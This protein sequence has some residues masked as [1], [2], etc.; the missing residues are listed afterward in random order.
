MNKIFLPN[1][2]EAVEAEYE[3][4]PI[5]EYSNNPYI[6]AL[7]TI[8]D[9][10]GIIKGLVLN[11]PFDINERNF[12]SPIRIHILQR[13]YK[14]FQPLPIHLEVWRTIDTLIRQ[15]Y[16]A[17][18]P[19]D[20]EYRQY[21]NSIGSNVSKRVYEINAR[22][23][24]TT[25]SSCGLIV[26]FSGM[27]KTTCVNR[28]LSNF[29]Q[30]ICHNYYNDNHFNQL[31]LT[32]LRLEAP[33]SLKSL[34]IQFF[35]KTD[36]L[37]GT[38]NLK[39]YMTKNLS[40]DAL[41]S[42]MGVVCNNI[43]LGLLIID[44]IQNLNRN[45]V[46]QIMNF[47]TSLINTCGVPVLFIGTP[48]SY[49]I[50]SNELRIARRVTGNSELIWNNMNNDRQFRVLL[51]GIW[52]YQ[53]TRKPIELTENMANLFYN[54]TQG[55]SDLVVKL[56]VNTQ[57]LAIEVGTEEISEALVNKVA[58]EQ[59]KFIK[60]MIEAIRSGN[61]YKINEYEDIRR[62]DNDST[63]GNKEKEEKE[64]SKGRGPTLTVKSIHKR[65]SIK[66]ELEENDFRSIIKKGHENKKSEYEALKE[67]GVIDD[68]VWAE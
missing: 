43:G 40:T 3:L 60:P 37:L 24:F 58:E 21:L 6:Q 56:F 18:N 49:D 19:F 7:P 68:M 52:R 53:W 41:L 33:T 9:K 59:F 15:G 10:K 67:E 29:P 57:R 44:E 22:T 66:L 51:R 14:V 8:R 25:T 31:Q 39:R 34:T 1:G 4:Q 11:Q 54:L 42:L 23:S 38:N 65:K 20:R 26:G 13:I 45:S 12:D 46:G 27:G 5:E 28:V 2:M 47:L 35:L 63:S 55:I 48:A 30:I 32:W 16:I 50:F 64:L 36:E 17:R 62:I 61:Q